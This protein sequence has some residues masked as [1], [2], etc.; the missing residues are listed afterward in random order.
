MD[1]NDKD[2]DDNNHNKLVPFFNSFYFIFPISCF[3]LFVHD[4]IM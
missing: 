1:F 3:F 2:H 4:E